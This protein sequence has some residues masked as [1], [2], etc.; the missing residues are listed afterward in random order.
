MPL[1]FESQAASDIGSEFECAGKKA[2]AQ[3][4]ATQE[5][6]FPAIRRIEKTDQ[7]GDQA[8][9]QAV[10]CNPGQDA[11]DSAGDEVEVFPDQ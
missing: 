9:E 11:D 4:P 1:Q 3:H 6:P 7:E 2:Q 5:A 8:G 10:E